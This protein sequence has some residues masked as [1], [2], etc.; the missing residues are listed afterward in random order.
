MTLLLVVVVVIVVVIIGMLITVSAASAAAAAV[1]K[2]VVEAFVGV[3]RLRGAVALVLAP[4]CSRRRAVGVLLPRLMLGLLLTLT[5]R[6][7]L[8]VV[9][10]ETS[11][12]G[13]VGREGGTLLVLP[14]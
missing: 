14:L 3:V 9:G 8:G 10:G 7:L 6:S 5:M 4:A 2:V 12:G 13:V 1:V 11:C